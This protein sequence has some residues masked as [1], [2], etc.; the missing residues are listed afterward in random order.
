VRGDIDP[1][2][3]S[4]ALLPYF[5]AFQTLLSGISPPL[6]YKAPLKGKRVL[7]AENTGI[8]GLAIASL[9][10]VGRAKSIHIVCPEAYHEQMK[11][12]GAVPLISD[13]MDTL[14]GSIKE[15]VDIIVDAGKVSGKVRQIF[16]KTSGRLV[17]LSFPP[18]PPP[19]ESKPSIVPAPIQNFCAIAAN[20]AMAFGSNRASLY[21][22]FYSIERN[23]ALYK[24]DLNHIFNLL[25][26]R[27]IRP[28]IDKFVLLQ[29]VGECHQEL[30]KF[31]QEG[32]IVCE[33]W[34]RG[35]LDNMIYQT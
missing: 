11:S 7:V 31:Q 27:R 26:L 30:E 35:G 18:V 22:V 19:A 17:R 28:K 6:R 34:R 4:G 29:D 25:A 13:D 24:S 16:L 32:A 21:D 15:K 33:P 2:E 14:A 10:K 23:Q 9:C 5:I 8:I 1:S 20:M 12:L 3:A